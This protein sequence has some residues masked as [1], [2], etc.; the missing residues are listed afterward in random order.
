MIKAYGTRKL[1]AKLHERG[2]IV[3]RRRIGCIMK[4]QGLVSPTQFPIITLIRLYEISPSK[5]MN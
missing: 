2:L 3:S 1:K 5:Q 4:A